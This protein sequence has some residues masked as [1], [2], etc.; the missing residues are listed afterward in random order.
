MHVHSTTRVIT[1]GIFDGNWKFAF[2]C[3]GTRYHA[4]VTEREDRRIVFPRTDLCKR[5]GAE[6]ERERR[7]RLTCLHR[8][9]R[10]DRVRR[11]VALELGKIQRE[12]RIAGERELEHAM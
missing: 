6:N 11:S 1:E 12:A 2:R 3:S 5:I 10:V 7:V 8:A 4:E 9:D